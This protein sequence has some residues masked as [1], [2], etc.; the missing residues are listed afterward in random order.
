[1]LY[2]VCN[3][4]EYNFFSTLLFPGCT[5]LSTKASSLNFLTN[6]LKEFQEK[7]N[8][9]SLAPLEAAVDIH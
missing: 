9:T 6:L 1:M 2:I 4:N 3:E 8:H 7:R 5:D